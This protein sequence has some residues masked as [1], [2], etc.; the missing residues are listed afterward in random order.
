MKRTAFVFLFLIFS[1]AAHSQRETKKAALHDTAWTWVESY[2]VQKGFAKET[3][4]AC[5]KPI[6]EMSHSTITTWKHSKQVKTGEV[7]TMKDTTEVQTNSKVCYKFAVPGIEKAEFTIAVYIN[8]GK[9]NNDIPGFPILPD[10][11][12]GPEG[13]KIID[14]KKAEALAKETK[15]GAKAEMTGRKDSDVAEMQNNWSKV[16][17]KFGPQGNKLIW[18][19][20]YETQ[21]GNDPLGGYRSWCS[22]DVDAHTGEVNI[23]RGGQGVR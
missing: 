22:I 10:K 18:S 4:K 20:T 2:F 21:S 12:K 7:I 9:V 6:P 23:R 19:F 14:L 5:M 11:L 16:K 8:N 15:G 13:L 1:A 17:Q 3:L